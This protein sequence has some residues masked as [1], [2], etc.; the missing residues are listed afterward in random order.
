MA[1]ISARTL[2]EDAL[3]EALVI[4]PGQDVNAGVEQRAFRRLNN[5]LEVLSLDDN[6]IYAL[7][8]ES[9]T[10]TAGTSRYTI[11]SGGDFDTSRPLSISAAAGDTFIR[12]A[13][14]SEYNVRV[15]SQ[16]RYRV[17]PNKE[18]TGR[19]RIMTYTPEY[20][21]GKISFYP[22]PNSSTDVIHFRSNTILTSFATL[23]TE[24]D[25]APGYELATMLSLAVAISQ[26]NGKAVTQ[27]LAA[28]F[29]MAWDAIE[30]KNASIKS[31]NPTRLDELA[32]IN[33]TG[34]G[35]NILT[36]WY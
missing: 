24:V 34:Y 4:G 33:R 27:E 1:A 26:Q 32:L 16:E 17:E 10:L 23:T 36:G 5:M 14:G 6:K 9:E 11:G 3:H 21:L 2:I 12:D 31:L 35:G 28:S 29:T 20:P 22:E 30:S 7:T 13:N 8:E 18:N 19:P 15:L 25:F